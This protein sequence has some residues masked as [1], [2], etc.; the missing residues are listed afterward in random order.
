MLPTADSCPTFTKMTNKR[1]DRRHTGH[2]S[3]DIRHCT[4]NGD[5]LLV[6]QGQ[7]T[8]SAD[9]LTRWLTTWSGA[10]WPGRPASGCWQRESDGHC[11]KQSLRWYRN[12]WLLSERRATPYNSTARLCSEQK[13][14][15]LLAWRL[16]LHACSP[17]LTASLRQWSMAHT[18]Y[19]ALAVRSTLGAYYDIQRSHADIAS[20]PM[21]L[22][23]HNII[24]VVYCVY[25]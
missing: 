4:V 19:A 8:G 13:T 24:N 3:N 6:L 12:S 25:Y 1:T 11:E 2:L 10:A 17:L 14:L 21:S 15:L 18:C 7:Y 23:L 22:G 16:M 20:K 9:S 5:L